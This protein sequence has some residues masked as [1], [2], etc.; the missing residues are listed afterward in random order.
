MLAERVENSAAEMM[1]IF[2]MESELERKVEKELVA[3]GTRQHINNSSFN[4][5]TN[6]CWPHKL[7]GS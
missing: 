6:L 4:F 3:R 5:F 1:D 7:A 2:G